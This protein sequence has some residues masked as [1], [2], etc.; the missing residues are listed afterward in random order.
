MKALF[1]AVVGFLMVMWL[2]RGKASAG[3]DPAP[4]GPGGGANGESEPMI[5]CAYCGVHMP[6]SEAITA[7]TGAGFCSEEHRLRHAAR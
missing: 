2:L 3:A 5:R 7:S 1:W 4:K 6:A